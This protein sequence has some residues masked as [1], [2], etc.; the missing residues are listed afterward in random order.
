VRAAFVTGLRELGGVEGRTITIE[1]RSATL[2]LFSS[3][4]SVF[5]PEFAR[6]MQRA[7]DT[8]SGMGALKNAGD[9]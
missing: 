4:D 1:Y 3:N 5:P 6:R 9:G 2:W 8:A 7:F